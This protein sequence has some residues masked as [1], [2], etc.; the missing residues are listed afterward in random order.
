MN[1]SDYDEKVCLCAMNRIF[2]F[3]PKIGKAMLE[4]LGSA[5]E[6]FSLGEKELR[7]LLGPYS[8]YL[9]QINLRELDRSGEEL[10]ALSREGCGFVG[11]GEEG[12]PL[13]LAECEDPP[14][15]LYYKGISPPG[16][17]F[18]GRPF[19]SVVGTRDISMYGREWTGKIVAALS[20]VSPP[21]AIVS[22]LAYGV[23]FMAHRTALDNSAPTIAVMATGITEIYPW[24]HRAIAEEIA[25]T[26]GC[27]LVTDY[28]PATGPAKVNFL[29]RN[30]IIAGMSAATVLTESKIKGG[31]MIT[32]SLAFSYGREVYALPGRVDDTR[33]QGC[34]K[35]IREKVAEPIGSPEGLAAAL[36]LGVPEKDRKRDFTETVERLYGGGSEEMTV[37]RA[38]AGLIRKI[39]GVSLDELCS[40]TGIPYGRVSAVISMMEGDG[41]VRTDLLQRCFIA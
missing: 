16:E 27:A 5:R 22:G 23:D 38:I 12:Y 14:V 8:K 36:G 35:L 37:I 24:R 7:A 31:G 19:V 21:P 28:P 30:R 3:E 29:R 32:A 6:V 40:R 1:V 26:P 20:R 39:R 25:S 10:E 15:G 33:S 4:R 41:L 34:L 2:G 13:V 9:S 17:V 18:G 11:L